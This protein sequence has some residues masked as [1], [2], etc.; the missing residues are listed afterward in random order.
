M[1]T[2]SGHEEEVDLVDVASDNRRD[3]ED[4]QPVTIHSGTALSPSECVCVL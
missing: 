2:V 3:K 4:V 1:L